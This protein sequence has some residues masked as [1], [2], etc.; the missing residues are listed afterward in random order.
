MDIT[1]MLTAS[2]KETFQKLKS[3]SASSMWTMLPHLAYVVDM[4]KYVNL[5][6]SRGGHSHILR[7]PIILRAQLSGA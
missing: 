5:C 7:S 2:K 6:H 1:V 4:V 3:K